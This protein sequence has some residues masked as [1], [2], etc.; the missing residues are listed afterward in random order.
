MRR[1]TAES[2]E[3]GAFSM[4]TGLTVAPSMYGDTDEIVALAES[5][6]QY[7]GAFYATHARVW[8]GNHVGAIEEAMEIGRRAGVPVQYSHLAI[9]D[10]RA[11]GEG[12][13]MTGVIERARVDW[14]RRNLRRLPIHGGR[15]APVPK[16]APVAA[17]GRRQGACGQAPR[18]P[19]NGGGP[20]TT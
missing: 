7:D 5:F 20:S 18:P 11:Y 8:A 13:E 19:S 6:S 1:L 12:E 10:P 17:G 3:Q 15:L 9:I 4:S 14:A 16:R 2:V